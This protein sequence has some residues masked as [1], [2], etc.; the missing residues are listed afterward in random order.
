[1]SEADDRVL[2]IMT[3]APRAGRVKTRL[4]AVYTPE[5]IVALYRALVEDTIDLARFGGVRAVAVCPAGDEAEVAQWLSS[6][7]DVLPQRG[8]GLAAGLASTF[9]QLCSPPGRRVI[10]FNADSPHLPAVVLE[11]AFAAL[12]N[13]DLVVG[14]CDDGGYYLVG[15]TRPHAGLFDA[16]AMGGD[17]ACSVLLAQASRLGLRTSLVAEHYDI[18][19]PTDVVR[20]A[21]DLASEPQRASR[22][23]AILASWGLER[24]PSRASERRDFTKNA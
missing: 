17:S 6:D 15:A 9:E 4:A 18:D 20:L 23:A 7:V 16:T 22:T 12:A 19:L 21:G 13:D 2:A 14:P 8:E 5:A 24:A 1:M 3:K 10:A 11:S